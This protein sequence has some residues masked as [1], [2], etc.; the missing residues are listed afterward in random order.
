MKLQTLWEPE[1]RLSLGLET[2]YYKLF[3]AKG[4]MT[5]NAIGQV[6]L[7][8]SLYFFLYGCGSFKCVS[9]WISSHFPG[10]PHD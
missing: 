3:R 7:S 10:R 1:Y 4:Q 6:D 9:W 8:A 2:G 5:G